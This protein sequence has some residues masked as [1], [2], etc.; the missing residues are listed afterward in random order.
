MAD[1]ARFAEL[2]RTPIEAGDGPSG[3]PPG[4]L[5]SYEAIREQTNRDGRPGDPPEWD[6][7]VAMA[8]EILS[9]QSKDF[10]TATY[11]AVALLKTEGPPGLAAGLGVLETMVG[12]HWD[13]GY[14]PV[15]RMRGRAN[16]FAWLA[17]R[18]APALEALEVQSAED[19]TAVQEALQHS[20]SLAKLLDER[21]GDAD[22]QL[23]GMVRALKDICERIAADEPEPAPPPPPPAAANPQQANPQ[24]PEAGAPAAPPPEAQ[25]SAAAPTPPAPAAAAAPPAA[26]ALESKAD[27]LQWLLKISSFYREHEPA[28]PIAYQLLRM[29]RWSGVA[30]LPPANPEGVTPVMPP[31]P[32]RVAALQRLNQAADWATLLQAAEAGFRERPLWLDPHR[33][34]VQAAEALGE[35]YRGVRD[36]IVGELRA[37]LARVPDL[38]DLAFQDGTKSAD[39][40]TREWLSE[41]LAEASGS[42]GA[43]SAPQA[44][45][46]PPLDAAVAEAHQKGLELAKKGDIGQ[47]MQLRSEA[48]GGDDSP[49]GR[50]L[51]RLDWCRYCMNA[52]REK[53]ALPLLEA[54]EAETREYGL[55]RWEPGLAFD[56]LSMLYRCHLRL[57]EQKGPESQEHKQQAE[58]A[59]GRLCQ[60]DPIAASALG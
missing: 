7:V 52:S 16:A 39:A 58:R 15:K 14:P 21:M 51:M 8:T 10:A 43:A 1:L 46:G 44:P 41:I 17:E 18:A 60:I 49:R 30:G 25:V 11:L 50:F 13:T 59:F 22:P 35:P 45:S 5:E 20:Q 3:V 53:I 19:K 56:T 34:A 4:E 9:T 32:E 38:P 33:H 37:L 27:A 40:G 57:A 24:Q 47:A 42:G 55:D 28:S 29:A 6:E 54:L 2:G 12:T 23:G 26:G 48:A 31:P 36:A